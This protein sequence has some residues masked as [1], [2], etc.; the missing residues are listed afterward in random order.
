MQLYRIVEA[1]LDTEV[2]LSYVWRDI[3]VIPT[4]VCRRRRS[5]SCLTPLLDERMVNALVDVRGRGADVAARRDRARAVH[6][7]RQRASRRSWPT[8]S[9]SCAERPCAAASAVSAYRSSSGAGATPSNRAG[10]GVGIQALRQGDA[11]VA[12]GIA[13]LACAA[14]FGARRVGSRPPTTRASGGLACS[15]GHRAPRRRP[16]HPA[17]SGRDGRPR[18]ARRRLRRWLSSA[19]ASIRRQA[20]SPAGSW[21][22]RAR[23]LGARA[24]C[25]SPHRPGRHGLDA[26]SSWRRSR[27]AQHSSDRC[28]WP[29]VADPV[30]GGAP[31]GI[32][33]VLA[34]LA[35]F[36][37]AVVLAR[38]L[39][40]GVG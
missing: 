16:R 33:G 12:A 28:C 4:H 1:L 5:C 6:P 26:R 22:R 35:I 14:L 31:L 39:R 21:R 2:V 24:G 7:G 10:G 11:R 29:L 20:S 25:G 27:S 13:S 3:R 18:P 37:V 32:A 19:K 38:S 30:R 8:G 40:S 17:G 9:G 34:V 15:G 36:A 23:L